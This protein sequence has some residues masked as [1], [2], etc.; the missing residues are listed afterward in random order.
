MHELMKKRRN[1]PNGRA[2]K[3]KCAT[4]SALRKL[5]REDGPTL[6]EVIMLRRDVRWLMRM[7]TRSIDVGDVD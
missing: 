1:S 6:R 7:E 3:L 2:L 4:G 5:C